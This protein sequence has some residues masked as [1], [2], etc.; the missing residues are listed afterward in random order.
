MGQLVTITGP[1][2]AKFTVDSDYAENFQQLL[3][4][5]GG[6][7][8]DVDPSQSGGF[9]N[10]NIFGTNIPSAHS[11]GQAVDIN[12][13]DNP[14]GDRGGYVD[15]PM[16][17]YRVVRPDVARQAASATGLETGAN[18]QQPYDPMHFQVP[19]G[20]G[21]RMARAPA[22]DDPTNILSMLM[23]PGSQLP[24]GGVLPQ[25]PVNY[26]DPTAELSAI[27]PRSNS[28]LSPPSIAGRPDV[29][30]NPVAANDDSWTGWLQN[31]VNRAFLL[32]A[33]IS[34]MTPTWG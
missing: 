6:N 29:R 11:R 30:T 15:D 31:P 23:P 26:S 25:A 20:G 13:R 9:N 16:R 34:M 2:G 14:V 32:Q 1:S 12:W 22:M 8:V 28:V 10:R 19:R 27:P 4:I 18:W 5:M 17:Q 7:S 3:S 33:G 24:P 21:T